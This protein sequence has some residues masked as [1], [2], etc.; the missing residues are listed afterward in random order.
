MATRPRL[1]ERG[2]WRREVFARTPERGA[3]F[4]IVQRAIEARVG[5]LGGVRSLR[6]NSRHEAP[7]DE[8]AVPVALRTDPVGDDPRRQRV[9]FERTGLASTIDSLGGSYF[10]E[11]LSDR[12]KELCGDYF[13]NI[14]NLAEWLRPSSEVF[15]MRRAERCLSAATR[16]T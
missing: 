11:A 12:M 4:T 14:D 9:I 6:I 16:T 8:E 7:P 13:L 10:G 1:S 5:V 15:R 3:P 2:R